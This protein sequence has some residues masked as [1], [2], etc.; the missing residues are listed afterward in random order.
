[1]KTKYDIALEIT[2]YLID[3]AQDYAG[4]LYDEED[5][6][7]AIMILRQAANSRNPLKPRI[8]Y[9]L[10][11]SKHIRQD[12]I[13]W[14]CQHCN[15]RHKTSIKAKFNYC[16]NCGGALDWTVEERNQI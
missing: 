15:E 7:Y 14:E 11:D 16:P 13:V 2:E 12:T 9:Q 8:I 6:F 10:H 1:V 3:I 4:L 5:I